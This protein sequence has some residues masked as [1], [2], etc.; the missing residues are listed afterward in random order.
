MPESRLHESDLIP[1]T[2][3]MCGGFL[4]FVDPERA[5]D[6]VRSEPVVF[7]EIVGRA[8]SDPCLEVHVLRRVGR[9]LYEIERDDTGPVPGETVEALIARIAAVHG[10]RYATLYEAEDRWPPP[11]AFL[12]EDRPQSLTG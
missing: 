8:G 12:A 7:A 10:C 9:S 11:W 2:S 1:E 3:L 4:C 6:L 5:K